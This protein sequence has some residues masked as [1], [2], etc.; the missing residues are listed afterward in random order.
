M[1]ALHSQITIAMAMSLATI[2]GS[3]VKAQDTP[4]GSRLPGAQGFTTERARVHAILQGHLFASCTVHKRLTLVRRFLAETDPAAVHRDS[5]LLARELECISFTGTS[6][7][8]VGSKMSTS[9][10]IY[11]GNLAEAMLG[12]IKP[13]PVLAAMPLQREYSM[14]L[15]TVSGREPVVEEM[16]VCV[17]ETN[18]DAIVVLLAT[19]PET[20]AEA[21]RIQQLLP[22]VVKCLMATARL[23]AN[24]QSM[25]AGLAEVLYHRAERATAGATER[26]AVTPAPRN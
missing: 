3:A 1:R 19:D 7:F 10:D 18:P 2:V 11:R 13:M 23:T 9:T 6:D 26:L 20:A 24:R 8:V 21:S 14:P 16:A 12:H 5:N 4:L 25:R 15:V 22:S 17:A